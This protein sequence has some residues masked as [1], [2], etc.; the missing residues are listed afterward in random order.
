MAHVA[1]EGEHG[2][3]NMG[4]KNPELPQKVSSGRGQ[5]VEETGSREEEQA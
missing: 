3:G 2:R 4:E 5:G 1:G